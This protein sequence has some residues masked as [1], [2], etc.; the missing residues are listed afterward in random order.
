MD[1]TSNTILG[2]KPPAPIP[3]CWRDSSAQ[4]SDTDTSSV[5]SKTSN[6]PR[7]SGTTPS[8][9]TGRRGRH[10]SP[11]TFEQYL[12]HFQNS[13]EPSNNGSPSSEVDSIFER[14][15]ISRA[16]TPPTPPDFADSNLSKRGLG[17]PSP[18][19]LCQSRT[20]AG[21][22][23]DD[24]PSR[25]RRPSARRPTSTLIDLSEISNRQ[26]S[27]EN[28]TIINPSGT[29]GRERR[30]EGHRSGEVGPIPNFQPFDPEPKLLNTINNELLRKI[31]C[32]EREKKFN[33]GKAVH[34]DTTPG[35]IYIFTLPSR[36]G[37]VKIGKTEIALQNRVSQQ[38]TC[39][40]LSYS[41]IQDANDKPFRWYGIVE[42]L[43]MA[44]LH[45]C[46]RRLSCSKRKKGHD[47]WYEISEEKALEVVERWRRW[48]VQGEPYDSNGLLTPFWVQKHEDAIRDPA[49]I[50]WEEW[51][52]P[53]A[54]LPPYRYYLSL[55]IKGG[56]TFLDALCAFMMHRREQGKRDSR[57][58]TICNRGTPMHWLA[59]LGL[60]AVLWACLGKVGLATG[61]VAVV[62]LYI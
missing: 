12:T 27:I 7:Y 24:S 15:S 19:P 16:S 6:R 38:K 46:R 47:E 18:S 8:H 48:M 39:C 49:N 13:K 9:S 44:E 36:P 52:C 50:R 51:L 1:V 23:L 21:P 26:L 57:C 32:R 41:L 5:A 55:I 2:G 42:Q 56:M 58:E 40:K 4:L 35:Y 20:P 25:A 30:L 43:V 53:P 10:A 60:G 11:Q 59:F 45:N 29:L 37:Y 54:P 22:T 34:S 61:V 28:D 33:A 3:G 14:S 62:C 17:S 31:R